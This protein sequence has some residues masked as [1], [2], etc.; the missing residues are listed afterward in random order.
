MYSATSFFSRTPHA[1]RHLRPDALHRRLHVQHALVLAPRELQ[2]RRR[3]LRTQRRLQRAL[4]STRPL[5]PT[6]VFARSSAHVRTPSAPSCCASAA[7]TPGSTVTSA[8][9]R[10]AARSSKGMYTSP[11]G[12]ALLWSTASH[13]HLF[14]ARRHSS[15]LWLTPTLQ[16]QPVSARMRFLRLTPSP[17]AH[18]MVWRMDKN[19]WFSANMDRSQN[20]SS[21]LPT[22]TRVVY[23]RTIDTICRLT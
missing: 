5:S 9:A 1:V 3:R 12:F 16:E 4:P 8:S 11:S 10:Q 6:R 17:G 21:Q 22:C 23:S 18:L 14:V 7:P 13:T 2:Q 19:A 15:R 20:S